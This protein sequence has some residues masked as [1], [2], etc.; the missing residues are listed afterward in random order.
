MVDASTIGINNVINNVLMYKNCTVI[1]LLYKRAI[2]LYR[3]LRRIRGNNIFKK[4]GR[5][6]YLIYRP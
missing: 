1:K 4:F 3:N 2:L 5:A 6:S